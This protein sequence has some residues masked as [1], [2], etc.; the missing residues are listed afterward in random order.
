MLPNRRRINVSASW[1]AA[2]QAFA[3]VVAE[4]DALKR[5]LAQ[6]KAERDE[7]RACLREL[8]AAVTARWKAEARVAELH[9]ERELARANAVERDPKVL[10]H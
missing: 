6:I 10:L 2:K 5:E 7:F 4:R 9:R 3:T 1:A 8:S